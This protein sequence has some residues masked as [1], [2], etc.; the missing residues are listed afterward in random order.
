VPEPKK[1][2]R[3]NIA[4]PPRGVFWKQIE[5]FGKERNLKDIDDRI[6][7]RAAQNALGRA[8]L[9]RNSVCVIPLRDHPTPRQK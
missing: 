9:L 4:P 1:R 5:K 6:A 2:R 3:T 8:L 7:H